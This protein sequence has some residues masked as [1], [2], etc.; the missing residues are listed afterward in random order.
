VCGDSRHRRPLFL[1]E[2]LLFIQNADW[3]EL[4]QIRGAIAQRGRAG[5]HDRRGRPGAF[6]EE[7][8][9]G[10]ALRA[11]WM[12]YIEGKTQ[13]EVSSAVGM[14]DNSPDAKGTSVRRLEDYFAAMIYDSVPYEYLEKTEAGLGQYEIKPGALD[15]KHLQARICFNTKLPFLTHPD[16]CKR[17]VTA[18]WP[19]AFPAYWKQLHQSIA[20]KRTKASHLNEDKKPHFSE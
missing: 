9:N 1:D 13:R 17:I 12:R 14:P 15:D 16:E 2:A 4:T 7:S 19:R 6:K 20:R 10:C 11:V 8:I 3:V 5:W 18:L